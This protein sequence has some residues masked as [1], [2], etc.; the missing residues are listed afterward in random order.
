MHVYRP[1]YIG[2][3]RCDGDHAGILICS[4]IYKYLI[5]TYGRGQAGMPIESKT[6]I[7][8]QHMLVERLL[9]IYMLVGLGTTYVCT[10]MTGKGRRPILIHV[11]ES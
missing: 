10:R 11:L 5:K 7:C 3:P 9:N 8:I 4:H 1:I 2:N 6:L